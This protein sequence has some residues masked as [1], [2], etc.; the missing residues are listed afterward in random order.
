M[1]LPLSKKKYPK[2]P[3]PHLASKAF[4]GQ[5]LGR[6]GVDNR[7][8]LTRFNVAL[9]GFASGLSEIIHSNRFRI[10][11]LLMVA[12]ADTFLDQYLHRQSTKDLTYLRRVL[13]Q[14]TLAYGRYR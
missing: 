7:Y 9:D 5:V 13:I 14:L 2:R 12:V 4:F 3:Q 1:V 6:C 11:F 10:E 8:S